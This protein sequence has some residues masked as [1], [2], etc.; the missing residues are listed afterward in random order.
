MFRCFNILPAPL[1]MCV[2]ALCIHPDGHSEEEK[3]AKMR[4]SK[5]E[6]DLI[7]QARQEENVI[8]ILLLG[9][10]ESGKSTLVKQ[11]KLMH[12]NGFSKAELISLKT[13]VL[14]NLLMSIKCVLRGMGQLRIVLAN[15]KNKVHA[16]SVLSCG[17]CFGDDGELLPFVALAFCALCAD[18]GVR[19]AAARGYEFE[20]NDSALYFF[21]NISRIIAP[22]YVPVQ[23]DV[24]WVRVRTCGIIETQFRVAHT[25][26]RMYDVGGQRTERKKWLNYFDRVQAVLFVVGLSGYDMTLMEDPSMNRLQESLSIFTSICAN[27][28]F[29]NT[30]LILFMNKCDLFQEKILNSQ[31]H[32]RLYLPSYEGADCDV[33]AAARHITAMFIACNTTPDKTIYHHYTTA[34]DTHSVGV[35]FQ[36]VLDT[37]VKANLQAVSLL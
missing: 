14:D 25:V 31:R 30:T 8:K 11:I 2:R 15:K 18:Q 6:Q 5:I 7:E 27:T 32:L 21:K 12:S 16:R 29:R 9:A 24:L 22:N 13:A 36:V 28:V 23:G 34:T 10:A 3:R 1:Q 35:V 19:A 33:T 26:F 4:N 37:I 20:L 17:Q